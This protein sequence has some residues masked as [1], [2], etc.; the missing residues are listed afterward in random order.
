MILDMYLTQNV[1]VILV[2]IGRGG[3]I[4]GISIALK[5]LKPDVKIIGVE[6]EGAKAML[7]SVKVKKII[8]IKGMST[9]AD[10]IAVKTPGEK[11]IKSYKNVLIRL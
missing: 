1:G 4:S 7:K 9:I 8:P 6:T 3:L 10:G 5:H 11:H 2:P